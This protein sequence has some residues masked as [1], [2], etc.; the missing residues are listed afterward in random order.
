MQNKILRD[1]EA[2]CLLVE[3]IA[4]KSQDK[5]WVVSIDGET[6]KHKMIRRV[7]MDKFYGIVFGDEQAFMKLCRALPSILDDVI[8]DMKRESLNNTV[9]QELAN[10]SPDVMKSLYLLAFKTYEGF[11][12]F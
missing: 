8:D 2:T 3:A 4:A 1:S 9:F 5:I 7:S 10:I 6:F 11:D 12:N